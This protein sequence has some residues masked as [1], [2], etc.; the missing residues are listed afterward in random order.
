M[1]A[2]RTSGLRCFGIEDHRVRKRIKYL[3]EYFASEG[4]SDTGRVHNEKADL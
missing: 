2:G 3:K 4:V 1:E